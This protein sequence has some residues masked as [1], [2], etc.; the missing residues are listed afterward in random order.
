MGKGDAKG[1]GLHRPLEP[2]VKVSGG[3]AEGT[4]PEE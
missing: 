3:R 1:Y 2:L 4:H